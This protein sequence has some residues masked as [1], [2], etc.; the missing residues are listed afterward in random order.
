MSLSNGRR[1]PVAV[2]AGLLVVGVL[3]ALSA[4]S[5]TTDPVD[6]ED[7]VGAPETNDYAITEE[8]PAG[9]T[10]RA[11]ANVNLRSGANTDA[12]I[13]RVIPLGATVKVVD[14]APKNGF[15]HVD[16]NG[17]VGWSHGKYY[18]IIS[19]GGLNGSVPAGTSLTTT[20]DLNLRSG[21][22]TS[23]SILKVVPKGGTVTVV[24]PNPQN[25]F[26]NV[27]SAGTV[28]WMSGKYLQ[29]GT[30]S[31][32]GGST[33]RDQA[34]VRAQSG[35]GF[36]YWWGHG[37]FR[38]EGPTASTKGSCSGGCPSCTHSG[39]YGGDCSGFVAK[40]WQVPSSNN[41]LTVDSHPYS[42]G[43]FVGSSSQW[44]TVSRSNV[45]KGDA[46]VYN[47]NGA[48]HIFIYKSGDGWGT[49][50][51]Y[52]CKGCSY[53]CIYGSRTAASNYKAIRRAGW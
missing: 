17:T 2:I 46:M 25:G 19:D 22:G 44:S 32:G 33:V 24:D 16:H 5:A 34:I 30:G 29:T 9:T 38:P 37:R 36:S 18:E 43:T 21:P 51:A 28:G 41:D 42:T 11:T 31:G 27:N 47:Q 13:L 23:N 10:L 6:S 15:Y 40:V 20:A 26:Y 1:S 8:V 48:G 12:S 14:S 53:G 39:S 4:C 35:M 52:E 45:L 7:L 3:V 49:M 50:Y